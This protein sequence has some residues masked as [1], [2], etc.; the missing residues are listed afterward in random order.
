MNTVFLTKNELAS[1]EQAIINAEGLTSAEIVVCIKTK[2]C[3]LGQ[4]SQ[5][6]VRKAV[7]VEAEKKLRDLCVGKTRDKNG[8]II[9]ISPEDRWVAVCGDKAVSDA[10]KNW[11][12]VTS[13]IL[14]GIKKSKNVQG[15]IEAI[16]I[17]GCRLE[18]HFPVKSDDRNEIPDRIVV[19]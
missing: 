2:S 12:E 5:H 6:T 11:Q 8:V 15:I 16:D 4:T 17:L 14:T 10:I 7:E 13:K 9:L 19:D 3:V 18:K 1:I